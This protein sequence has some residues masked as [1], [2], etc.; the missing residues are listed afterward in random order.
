VRNSLAELW[1]TDTAHWL[2]W[3]ADA[4]HWLT[5][6]ADTAHWL[7]WVMA[8][9]HLLNSGEYPPINVEFKVKIA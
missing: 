3:V 6:V 8:A 7:N 2:T 1:V 9:S 5:W 4:A